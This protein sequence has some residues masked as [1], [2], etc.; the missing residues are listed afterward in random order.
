[1][2]ID[3]TVSPIYRAEGMPDQATRATAGPPGPRAVTERS[4][5]TLTGGTETCALL[6]DRTADVGW[7]RRCGR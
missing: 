7:Q 5:M 6:R 3:I 1:M 4:A 2:A